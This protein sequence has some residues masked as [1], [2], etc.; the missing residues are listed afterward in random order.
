MRRE[1]RRAGHD[2]SKYNDDFFALEYVDGACVDE[3]ESNLN[4]RM[5]GKAENETL[6]SIHISD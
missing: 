4:R 3:N 5:E 2:F 1:T 6:Q